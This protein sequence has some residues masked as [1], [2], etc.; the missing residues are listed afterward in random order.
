MNAKFFT[1]PPF[2]SIYQRMN[3]QVLLFYKY[4][5]V[6]NPQALA[7]WIRQRGEALGFKGRILVAEEGLNG[8]LEGEADKTEVFAKELL[9][10]PLFGDMN[11]KRSAGN[12]E[13]FPRWSV[14]VRNEI[15]GTQF[16]QE[17]ADPRVLTAP[18]LPPEKLHEMF[19]KD[20]DFVIVDMRN[21][22]EIASGKFKKTFDP[23]MVASRDLKEA[24]VKLERYKDKKIVTVCTGGV[25]CEKMSAYLLNHGFKDV[26]QLENGIHAYMEKYPGQDFLGTLYT[27]DDRIVM[28]FGGEREIIGECHLCKDKTERYVNCA[29]DECHLH[30]LVCEACSP[31]RKNAYCSDKCKAH[32]A[33]LARKEQ[34][35][36]FFAKIEKVLARIR[37]RTIK[38]YHRFVW[39][40]RRLKKSA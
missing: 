20:E 13:A 8:I 28:D 39:M 5:T 16:T 37:Y 18:H 27:F 2:R 12:G 17:E 14:K 34:R 10:N 40:L 31:D 1:K 30:I 11:I 24:L 23:G 6:A 9:E 26:S 32:N 22:Y 36:Q 19:E 21:S 7:E 15:V 35:K 33:A 25:R 3:Y 38:R 29:N 4:V